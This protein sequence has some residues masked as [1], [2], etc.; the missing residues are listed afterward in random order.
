MNYA[1]LGAAIFVS[2]LLFLDACN[3]QKSGKA[4]QKNLSANVSSQKANLSQEALQGKKIASH[5]GCMNCHSTN[6]KSM[7][8]PPLNNLYGHKVTLKDGSTLTADSAY[9]IQSLKFPSKKV[10]AGYSSVMPRYNFLPP[11]KIK[12][13]VAYIKALGDEHSSK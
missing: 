6:G 9:I 10:A 12:Y 8:G 4:G 11:Q 5:Q 2:V 7:A 1:K 13:I 3:S